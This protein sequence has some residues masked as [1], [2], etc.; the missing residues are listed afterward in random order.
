MSD[1]HAA[2]SNGTGVPYRIGGRVESGVLTWFPSNECNMSG[3]NEVEA[4][5]T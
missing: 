2:L 5:F 1:S 4:Q 3:D